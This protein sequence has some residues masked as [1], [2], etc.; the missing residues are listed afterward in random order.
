MGL[1]VGS[2]LSHYRLV[3]RLGAG[4]MGEV[5]LAEDH[6]L[7]RLVAI[8]LLIGSPDDRAR[9]RLLE[10]ARAVAA[11]D[12]PAICAVHEIGSDPAAGDFIVMQYVEGEPLQER[13][14]RGRLR[15]SDTLALGARIADALAAAHGRG[16]IHRD[17]TPHNV[18][19]TPSGDPKLLDFGLAKRLAASAEAAEAVTRSNLTQPYAVVGT[20]GYMSPEQIRSQPVDRRSDLF[21]LGCLL[22]ECFTGRRAFDGATVPDISAAVLNVDPPPPSSIASDLD[23][24]HDAI[25]SRLLKKAPEDRFQSATE[26]FGALRALLPASTSVAHVSDSRTGAATPRLRAHPRTFAIIAVLGVVAGLTIWKQPWRR[27]LPDAPP[28]AARWYARGVEALREGTYAG[29]RSALEEAVRLYPSYAQAYSRLAEAHAELDDELSAQKAL[30][31]VSDLVPDASRLGAE[32]QLRL[33]AVRASVLRDHDKVIDVYQRL[34]ERRPNEAAGW[35]DLGRATEAASRLLAAR[36]HYGK[37]VSLDS[38]YAAAQLRLG[39]V[40]AR[41]GMTPAALASLDEAARLYRTAGHPEGEAAAL[42]Q[43][44]LALTARGEHAGARDLLQR[45]L[46]LAADP[47]FMSLRLRAQFDLAALTASRGDLA[48]AQARGEA[49]VREATDAGLQALAANGLVDLANTLI[50]A[51]RTDAAETHLARAIDLA[52]SRGASRTLARAQLQQA[53]LLLHM[54][55]NEDAIALAT[56]PLRWVSEHRE[57]G[58]EAD[59]KNI[60]SRAHENL[61]H[62]AEASRL[63]SEVL[64]LAES[65]QNNALIAT[66]LENLAGQLT[67]QGQLPEALNT[68]ERIEK[69]HRAQNDHRTLAYDLPNRAELLICL[70]RGRE[71]DVLLQEVEQQIAAGMELYVRR[72]R[73]V[74]ALRAL[75]ETTE[76]RF[77]RVEAFA[78]RAIRPDP[79]PAPSVSSPPVKPDSNALLGMALSEYAKSQLGRSRTPAAVLTGWLK[80]AST[81]TLRRELSYWLARTLV[82][83]RELAPAYTI[84]SEA[85]STPGAKANAEVRWRLAAVAAQAAGGLTVSPDGETLHAHART[86]RQGLEVTWRDH[87]AYFARPDLARLR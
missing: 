33:D 29:A 48:D 26:A 81:P 32:D 43:R 67:K 77:S 31:R 10:E 65:M 25:V 20:P 85:W 56:A 22:Y 5:F 42:L 30:L 18:M 23:A 12:H 86:D 35:V 51:G 39:G 69:I 40:Q 62:Y 76:L 11:L 78:A 79:P 8:K 60:V 55:R 3:R 24:S 49:A 16:I 4:G 2:E 68:R 45:V 37:A 50:A 63:A 34:V 64:Q 74:A 14:Q 41:T 53:S 47:R 36:E 71:A 52:N 84:A 70:G 28:E 17:L 1:D 82:A 13:L 57:V 7:H 83:R 73:R 75:L 72:Q 15:P 87:A 66:A 19:L 58:L 54:G 44:G 9:T 38:Q 21:A 59:G 46:Q 6:Q 80:D 27:G 61:E